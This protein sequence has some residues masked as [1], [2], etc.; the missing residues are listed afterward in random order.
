TIISGMGELHL[1]IYLERMR[2]EYQVDT[3]V[4]A[5]QVAYREA[6]TMEVEFSYVHKKQDGGPGEWA[7][8]V[9]K[10]GPCPD[11]PYRFVDRITGGAIPKHFIPACDAGFRAALTEGVLLGA[12]VLGVE[13][14]LGDGA[15]H[16]TDSSDLAF[17]KAARDALR[18]A[19][20]K[21]G[22]VVLE[23]IMSV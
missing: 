6:I 12:P 3:L 1:E 10:V 13:V 23:P 16:S 18:E 14:E 19:L 21:A 22:P 20:H 5:P 2:R 17:H 4:S 7:K 8:V 9:G 11:S 15:I